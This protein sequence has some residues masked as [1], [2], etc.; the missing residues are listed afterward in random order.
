M[1]AKKIKST[2]EASDCPTEKAFIPI[3]TVAPSFTDMLCQQIT[4]KLGVMP[5]LPYN[6]TSEQL[7]KFR[8]D[9][10]TWRGQLTDL[11]TQKPTVET[12]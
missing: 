2:I 4:D 10:F 8:V 3:A 6:H 1:P 9:L 7:E 11:I 5:I 12:T